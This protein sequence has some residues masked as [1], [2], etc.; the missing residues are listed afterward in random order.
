MAYALLSNFRGSQRYICK[1]DVVDKSEGEAEGRKEEGK[2]GGKKEPSTS[3]QLFR[4]YWH[5]S[6]YCALL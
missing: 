2:E 6:F 1:A 4:S 5:T 3:L